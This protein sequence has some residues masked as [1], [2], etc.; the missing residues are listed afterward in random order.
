MVEDQEEVR[1]LALIIL[2]ARGY[3]LLQAANGN[4]ALAIADRYDGPIHLLLTDVVMPGMNGQEL[5]DRLLAKQP[6]LRVLFM[7]GYA[8]NVITHAGMMGDELNYLLK[9]FTPATLAHKIRGL[10]GT[11]APISRGAGRR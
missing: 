3:R 11:T 8:E 5:A 9:P 2:R 1:E 6:S 7:S 4:E 10:L